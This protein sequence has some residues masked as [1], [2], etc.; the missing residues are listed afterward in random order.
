MT[1]RKGVRAL[2]GERELCVAQVNV[3]LTERELV[4]VH[5]AAESLGMTTSQFVR[6]AIRH[7]LRWILEKLQKGESTE[8]DGE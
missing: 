1:Y 6:E 5:S 3:K 8:A 7:Q 4:A 2:A